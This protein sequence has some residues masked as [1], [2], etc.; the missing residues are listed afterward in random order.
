MRTLSKEELKESINQ[1]LLWLN[2]EGG[3]RLILINYDLKRSKL[4]GSNLR[5]SD[6]S[7]S[8]LKRS[9]LRYSD[10]SD[11]D[12]SGSNLRRS[13]LSDSDL[14]RSDLRRSNLSNSNL[15]RSYLRG[16]NLRWSD[17]SES[18]LCRCNLENTHVSRIYGH[19]WEITVYP[20]SL[21]IGRERHTIEEWEGFTEKEIGMMD[22]GALP[23]W[24]IWKDSILSYAALVQTD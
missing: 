7:D 14:R 6:L 10:L 11:S 21:A 19:P 8:D 20:E 9:D 5:R 18:D 3:E 23:W 12:L 4:S 17:L 2:H 24:S 16:S 15:R 22:N 1:H 13:D